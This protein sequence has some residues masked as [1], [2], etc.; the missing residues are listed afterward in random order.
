M[1]SSWL[2]WANPL[3]YPLAVGI[4]AIVLVL[5]VRIAGLP[6]WLM[7]I[8]AVI[9]A[10]LG[11][12]WLQAQASRPTQLDNPELANELKSVRQRAKQL[13]AKAELLGQ[14]AA[15][16]LTSGDQLELLAILQLTC[17]RARELPQQL[18]QLAQ[19][20][21]GPDSLLSVPELQQ[22]LLRVQRKQANSAGISR[23]Q[24]TQLAASL[25]RNIQL[26]QQGEDAR[27]AQVVSLST[28][29]SEAA[30]V[31]QQLQNK[32]RT[33]DLSDREQTRELQSLSA[34]FTTT[35]E[36]VDLLIRR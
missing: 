25:K 22:Q 19:R 13:A 3:H 12:A 29:I 16:L 28:L 24:L 15:Q 35:Q 17:D 20:L 5:G 1:N 31:L 10:I 26:A 32:L 27:Q 34:A 18:E 11:A 21:Q 8:L 14:E 36:S 2:R 7:L 30:E 4:A 6:R 9:I 23:D 33:A